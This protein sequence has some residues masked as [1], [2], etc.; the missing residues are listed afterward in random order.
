M[1]LVFLLCVNVAFAE[2][3]S[4]PWSAPLKP[5]FEASAAKYNVPI[6]LLYTLGYFGSAF[7]NRGAEPTVEG[8]YGV[9]ALRKN[10]K[11]GNSLA[12]GA[13]LTGV[14]E[15][16]LKT[17][18][19]ANIEAG[20]AVL[21]SYAKMWQ[22]DRSKGL[23]AWLNVVIAYAGL[24]PVYSKMF[25]M[26]IYE[27][28]QK[29]LDAIN[30]G[31]ERLG[32]YAMDIGSVNLASLMPAGVRA[33]LD[34]SGATWYPAA[35]CNYST[36][37]SSKDT[38]IIHTAEGSASGT[39]SWFN[40][41]T[42]QVSSHYVVAESGAV[43]Q[44]VS[45]AQTAWHVGCLNSRS[46]GIEHEGYAASSSHPQALYDASALL[47]RD[48]CN[49]RSIPKAHNSCPPGI[50]GHID[51]NNCVCGPGHT[52]PGSGWDWTYYINKVNNT[53]PPPPSAYWGD[54]DITPSSKGGTG[55][56]TATDCGTYWYVF[57]HL[58]DCTARNMNATFD[59]GFAWNGRGYIHMDWVANAQYSS[60]NILLEYRKQNDALSGAS[61]RFNE[62]A[63]SCGWQSVLDTETNDLYNYNGVYVNANNSITSCLNECGAS[64]TSVREMHMYG[65]KY[66]Y[67][68]KWTC[69]GGYASAD[70]TQTT[71]RSFPWG[72][73]GVY[74]YP[75]VETGYGN[76]INTDLGYGGKPIGAVSTGDCG[77]ASLANSLNFKGNA[78][79]YGNGD[80]MDAYG[81]A[82]VYC[83]TAAGPQIKLGSDDG[84]R[85]WVNGT[86]K[87]T[88]TTAHGLS[89]D[90]FT[91]AATS[92]PVGWNRVLFKI[93][94][95]TS[96]F[97]GT[98]SLRNG[99]N[100]HLNEPNVAFQPDRYGGQ[101]VY[102]EQDS[103]YPTI[104]VAAFE[105]ASNPQP[106]ADVYTNDTTINA[107]GTAGISSG[108]PV[109]FWKVMH[110][111]WGYGISGNTNFAN[112]STTGT[113][114][115]HVQT[116]VTGHR[117]FHFFAVSKSGR[118]SYQNDGDTGGW[119]WADGT[120]GNYMD[121]FVDNVAPVAPS[122]M[123]V[124]A[125]STSQINLG[126]GIPLDQ[127]V[128]IANSATEATLDITSGGAN[129]YVRGDVGV[130]VRRN[131]ASI[132]GWGTGTAVNDTGLASNTMY[133]YDI[134]AR[135]NTGQ[136]RG[137]WHN[138]GGYVGTTSV[139]TLA[140]APIAGL[141]VTVPASGAYGNATWPGLTSS[142]FGTGNG[143]VTKFKYTWSTSP[144]GSIA[145]GEGTD[146]SSGALSALPG[147]EGTYY[148]YLR[149]YNGDGVG[150][151]SAEFGPYTISNTAPTVSIGAPS[152]SLT[153]GGP[154][155]YEITYGGADAVT[156]ANGDVTLNKIGTADGSVA[157]TGDGITTRTVTISSITGDGTLGISIAA[158]TASNG[159]NNAPAEGPSD[160]FAVDN[161]A[162]TVTIGAPSASLT[163]GG[164]VTFE[165]TYGGADTVTLA[166]G[167]VTLNKTG[168]ADGTVGVSGNI[169]T[170]SDITGDG[171]LGV[172]IAAN[173]ASDT[174]GN[175]APAAG[176]SD[177]FTVDNTAPT[178]TATPAGGVYNAA[179]SVTLTAPDSSAIYYTTD[180][181]EPSSASSTYS[182]AL[183]ITSDTTLRFF[184]ADAAGN[185]ESPAKQEI[186][187]IL[188][189][190]GSIADAKQAT[191]GASIRLGEKALYLKSGSFGYIEEANRISGMR[192]E[193]AI[194]ADEGQLICLTGTRGVTPDGE[195]CITVDRMTPYG[196]GTVT[197]WGTNGRTFQYNLLDGLCVTTWGLVKVG[198]V[199]ANS[200]VVTTGTTDT[201]ITVITKAAPT[202]SAGDFVIVTG[203]VGFGSTR[204]IYQK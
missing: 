155:T 61:T 127:G 139:Y 48:I 75:A 1:V 160:T 132:Y 182:G 165:I 117:R 104:D 73:A 163:K 111:D 152:A 65:D 70:V 137:T 180:G 71:G 26:E 21:D 23:D 59:P 77:A 184:A 50:L 105:G 128:N 100:A 53:A 189:D 144:S 116:G 13:S 12:V 24:D 45:E 164:P 14:S 90:Q 30:S 108:C 43:Y 169:V 89:R 28:M 166:T 2:A 34:Y 131:G 81:F 101:S 133:T 171:T 143:L 60:S 170:I 157:V 145:E 181:S 172:S 198:S 3:Q 51:A 177:T 37:T 197:P 204:V 136:S 79:A 195:P 83:P 55:W 82:W 140:E 31:G 64:A 57:G 173:T 125:A 9:M 153:K 17:D 114:W 19:A 188:A 38:V 119:N 201:E 42:A 130:S 7:E 29:G 49:R 134:A 141:N 39:L 110:F 161:T 92:F 16:T 20:A 62:C 168:T 87:Y 126:W 187:T 112:V 8:G 91:I 193:G 154:V 122:F 41:C 167:D 52:D 200:Y 190:N 5:M 149:S 203:A 162:P 94:N 11:G 113:T 27:K 148:L 6:E 86:L 158:G 32:F 194:S 102:G 88:D 98:M 67:L 192:I 124:T 40:N 183:S 196:P 118:T 56:A 202:V 58:A 44:C 85:V 63:Y 156:L 10:D 106:N 185:S 123:G 84:A 93:H 46:V 25:A 74:L 4:Q 135:D 95:G 191:P 66:V 151:G 22:V 120:G 78:S 15:D 176:P 129:G 174:A 107:N 69:L 80:N 179:Q 178:T 138:T 33:Q 72:E 199:S 109:P 150:N 96:G 99:G 115:S 18:P 103:W 36:A 47:T 175:G 146:W 147:S 159:G 68:N 97:E 121:V 186:Y 54:S 76:V 35:S 142:K